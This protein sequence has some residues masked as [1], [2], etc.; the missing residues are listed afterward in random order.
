MMGPSL[1]AENLRHNLHSNVLGGGFDSMI[2]DE[3]VQR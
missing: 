3:E 2:N 1:H